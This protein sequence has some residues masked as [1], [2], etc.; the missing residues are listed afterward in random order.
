MIRLSEKLV[1]GDGGWVVIAEIKDW[2]ETIKN[3]KIVNFSLE[4]IHAI[5]QDK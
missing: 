1:D 2:I 5:C 4:R 3:R